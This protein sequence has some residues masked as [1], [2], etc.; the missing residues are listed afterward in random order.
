MLKNSLPLGVFWMLFLTSELLALPQYAARS[1]RVCSN[2]HVNPL[3]TPTQK[4]WDNPD[5]KD[6]KCNMS[7]QGCHINPAGGGLRNAPGRFYAMSTLPT[8]G[9]KLRPYRD[10]GSRDI[11]LLTSML[12][13]SDSA[14]TTKPKGSEASDFSK[15]G[16]WFYPDDW[17]SYGYPL[18]TKSNQSSY[19]YQQDRMGPI[20]ADPFLTLGANFRLADWFASGENFIFPMQAEVGAAIHPVEHISL[21]STGAL[22][23][24]TE[25]LSGKDDPE[26]SPIKI[27]NAFLLIHELPFQSYF[28]GGLFLPEFGL[29]QEDHTQA[30]RKYFEMDPS[31]I[32][33]QV[34]GFQIG[35]APNYPYSSVSFFQLQDKNWNSTGL[36]TAFNLYWRDVSWGAGASYMGKWRKFKD[37]GDIQAL[38]VNGYFNLWKFLPKTRFAYP[39]VIQ[40]E[41]VYG[42]K[43]RT[44][45]SY[46]SQ[47]GSFVQLD[48]LVQNGL[49][50]KANFSFYDDDLQ[51]K[52]DAGYRGGLGF[53]WTIFRGLRYSVET[54]SFLTET[55]GTNA[56]LIMFLH[57]YL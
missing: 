8:L 25:G 28:Q 18:K 17:L 57:A 32:E 47:H 12:S 5:L 15:E 11:E 22:Q 40:M 23:G 49:N 9:A 19:A 26:Y 45:S 41:Y 36:G 44:A 4:A 48:Y 50:L 20:N 2:C 35:M 51:L 3:K 42:Y 31:L 39:I 27:Q 10:V 43:N 13:N 37:G 55:G 33:N 1:A 7:C 46:K 52:E 56:D 54:R 29:R 30:N 21:A 16:K 34:Q 53:D 24:R 6:R 38:S 14:S